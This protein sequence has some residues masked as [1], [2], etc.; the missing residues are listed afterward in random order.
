MNP[1]KFVSK[2]KKVALKEISASQSHFNDICTLVGH[3]NPMDAD[4]RGEFFTF[5][6]PAEKVGGKS[7]RADVW[8]KNKFIWE[9]KGYHANLD[10]AYEQLLL[11]R[12]SLGNPWLLITS[13]MHRII[14]HTNFP[15]TVKKVEKLELEDLLNPDK[16]EILKAAFFDPRLLEPSET[17][18]QVT[19][20]TANTFVDVANTLQKWA[21]GSGGKH[22]PEKLA[23]FIIRLLFCL[24]SEDLGLLPGELFKK[25]VEYGES[26]L[27]DFKERLIALFKIM[28]K[29]GMYGKYKI[30]NFNGNLFNDDFLPKFSGDITSKLKLACDLDWSN[31]DP[32]IFG[33]LFE[34]V[35]DESK[36]S[37]LGAHYTSNADIMLIVEPVLMEPLRTEWAEVK[38]K[39][40]K[41]IKENKMKDA[42]SLLKKYSSKI[43]SIR[44]LDPACG[45]GNFLYIALR[46]LLDLQ[47]SVITFALT[48]GLEKISLKVNPRQLYGIEIN[49]YAH[50]LAQITVWI[51]YLQWRYENGF[52]G[53]SEPI[54]QPL[55]N[56]K[57]MDAIIDRKN[58]G[59][60]KDPEWPNVD[61][62]IGNPPFIGDKKMRKELGDDYV[63]DLHMLFRDKIPGQS[64]LVCYWF[65]HARNQIETGKCKRAGLL[66]TQSIRGGASRVVLERIKQTGNIFLGISDKIWYQ[67]GASVHVS[68]IGF[69]NGSE[70][71]RILD[72]KKVKEIN[73]DLTSGLDLTVA[74]ILKEN[75]SIAFM[76]DTKVGPFDIDNKTAKSLLSSTDNL[77]GISNN[78]V[79]RPWINARDITGRPSNKWIIDFGVETTQIEASKY[80]KPFEYVEKYVKPFRAS[81]RSGDRMGIPWWIHQRP[82]PDFREAISKLTRYIVTPRVSKHRVFVW[83]DKNV[84]PDS[85]TIAFARDD[86]YFFGV[87]HSRVHELWARHKG[88]QLREVESGFRYT[89]KTTF[90]TFPFPFPPGSESYGDNSNFIKNIALHGKELSI[91]RNSWLYPPEEDIDVIISKETVRKR[92]YTVLYNALDY[93]RKEIRG[94]EHSIR[95]WYK[96]VGGLISLEEIEELDH[97]HRELDRSVIKAYKWHEALEDDEILT[98]LLKLNLERETTTPL[99]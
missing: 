94:K 34:R 10:K 97:I 61:I 18:Q 48:N 69:D 91:F 35:I 15:N 23:Q 26:G 24:F 43:S 72:H 81:A 5:E 79:V 56:I 39:V 1:H 37:Q 20:K 67:D 54:L 36:R 88:T 50:E 68:M 14:I 47:K 40:G 55:K 63:N 46:L 3:E 38:T 32:S 19:E 71:S 28:S 53:I 2:W 89:P 17:P 51:G 95:Q 31:I 90:K 82:R 52:S 84:L 6:E 85:A 13:D 59:K 73:P 98:N 75:E 9:Y 99:K 33:T 92:T 45:S 44:I 12:E 58:K 93:Y 25:V 30:P 78:D 77:N 49:P 16:L 8:Y 87:L 42:S 76:G 96:A 86:D 21:K 60:P 70:K 65:E 57:E 41:L 4:P 11:Y 66:A 27:T 62:I 80:K 74:N 64:D 7:G 22:D 83:K 29:G